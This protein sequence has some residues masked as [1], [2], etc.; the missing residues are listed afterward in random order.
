[1]GFS[2]ITNMA[3][4]GVAR[5]TADSY[6]ALYKSMERL[7]SGLK[8][9]RASDNPAGLVISEQ[10]RSR[11]ASLNQEIENTTQLINKY[12]TASST[13]M[14]M[15]SQLTELRTLAVG[16]A[17][18]G[19]ND[20][21]SQAAYVQAS[22]YIVAGYNDT[23][24]SAVYNGHKML[25]GSE[26]SLANVSKLENISLSSAE[27]AE[28]AIVVIDEAIAELDAVQIDLGA[29]QKNDL[30][31][32]RSSLEVTAQNLQAADSLLRDL[33]YALEVANMVGEMIKVQ[34]SLALMSHTKIQANSVLKMLSTK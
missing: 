11:I 23:A 16:A 27:N 15:R 13:V 34:T 21:S 18:E 5:K 9:N 7:A 3:A 25:D 32:R 1:M 24:D 17:N 20:A 2:I 12:E 6:A 30:E 4:L 29:T 26:G 22:A 19:V 31:S 8:I 28:A 14:E 10:F 33:D